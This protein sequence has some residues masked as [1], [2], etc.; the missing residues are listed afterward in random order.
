MLALFTLLF[1]V[2]VVGA[3]VSFWLGHSLRLRAG[4]PF[5]ARVVSS[6]TGGWRQ[7]DKS[8]FSPRYMLTGKPDYVVEVAGVHIPIEVK[9]NRV[10]AEPHPSDTMQLAA[11][12]LLVEET[13]GVR[14][15]YG[16][17]KYRDSTFQVEF[18]DQTRKELIQLLGEMREDL[19]ADDVLRNHADPHRCMACGYRFQC[20][21]DLH[22]SSAIHL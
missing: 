13:Y 1:L 9:P 3:V 8:L 19:H 20:G 22:G 15:S 10:A 7:V 4:I 21:Q 17:L 16:L 6:D 12:G 11:Y 5:R 18:T 14:P 2:V